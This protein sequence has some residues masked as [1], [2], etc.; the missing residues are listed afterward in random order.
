MIYQKPSLKFIQTRPSGSVADVC[1]ST[2]IAMGNNGDTFFFDVSG[3]GYIELRM[4]GGADSGCTCAMVQIVAYHGGATSATDSEVWA[5]LQTGCNSC[6][7]FQGS[8][9]QDDPLPSWS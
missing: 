5:A 4:F 3:P 2:A 9:F 8:P 1:W 6:P 7:R